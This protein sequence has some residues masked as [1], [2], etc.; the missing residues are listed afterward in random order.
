MTAQ[1]SN[2]KN[3]YSA[4]RGTENFKEDCILFGGKEYIAI[5]ENGDI[6]QR[7][8]KS[9]VV[10]CGRGHGK[11]KICDPQ[12]LI[13]P[14]S[15]RSYYARINRLGENLHS[16]EASMSAIAYNEA[17]ISGSTWM[18]NERSYVLGDLCE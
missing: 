11:P 3:R 14:S 13:K 17:N 10:K 8:Q 4:S 18:D 2:S 9:R 16:G 12:Y 15:S 6:H 7:N 1:S 5:R